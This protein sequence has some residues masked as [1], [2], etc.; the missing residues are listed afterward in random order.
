MHVVYLVFEGFSPGVFG[1]VLFAALLSSAAAEEAPLLSWAALLVEDSPPPLQPA[2]IVTT[3][4]AAQAIAK[5]LFFMVLP[6]F[7]FELAGRLQLFAQ[8]RPDLFDMIIARTEKGLYKIYYLSHI[9]EF[10]FCS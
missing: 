9:V 10:T 5:S 1:T 4:A 8:K 3:I 2:N 7:V 6:P